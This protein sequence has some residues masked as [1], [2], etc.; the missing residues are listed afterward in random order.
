MTT[1]R[2]S[3]TLVTLRTAIALRTQFD[4][5]PAVRQTLLPGGPL[6]DR[7][8]ALGAVLLVITLGVIHFGLRIGP[9]A[10]DRGGQPARLDRPEPSAVGEVRHVD[11]REH[12][13]ER[14]EYRL[15]REQLGLRGE[16]LRHRLPRVVAVD[17]D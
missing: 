2:G 7:V 9:R 14:A 15:R 8:R 4:V 6:A 10:G 17:E 1:V 16:L 5:G 3:A 11:D 13:Q 12:H